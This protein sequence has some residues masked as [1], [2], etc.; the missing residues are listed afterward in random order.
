MTLKRRARHARFSTRGLDSDRRPS[1]RRRR[2]PEEQLDWAPA[3]PTS[4]PTR[5]FVTDAAFT[6]W[7]ADEN[8][9]A[10]AEARNQSLDG[11]HPDEAP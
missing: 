8:E 10:E 5:D 11:V 1:R 2:R 4:G 3:T 7:L 6:S 9:I